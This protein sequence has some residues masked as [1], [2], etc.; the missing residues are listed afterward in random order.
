MVATFLSAADKFHRKV[1]L[2]IDEKPAE[3]MWRRVSWTP[4]HG[5]KGEPIKFTFFYASRSKSPRF[6]YFV[7]C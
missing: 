3:E 5:K 1:I 2:D 7:N 4:A 6:P